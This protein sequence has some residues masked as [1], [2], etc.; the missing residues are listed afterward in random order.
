ML[1][2]MRL[3]THISHDSHIH[4]QNN[5]PPS[6]I[7]FY[8][9][10]IPK[11]ERRKKWKVSHSKRWYLKKKKKIYIHFIHLYCWFGRSLWK[12]VCGGRF[13]FHEKRLFKWCFA[14]CGVWMRFCLIGFTF[15]ENLFIANMKTKSSE[16]C[17]TTETSHFNFI[18]SRFFLMIYGFIQFFYD[19][20]SL[21]LEFSKK[22][23]SK[24]F[25]YISVERPI[26]PLS[27]LQ[28]IFRKFLSTPYTFLL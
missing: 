8:A 4:T 2:T 21:S 28:Q 16:N 20:Y 12:S 17:F 24:V 26:Q 23:V 18:H 14:R 7:S 5:L 13:V 11:H 6:P 9:M 15:I 1:R 25:K 19:F 10:S 22:N 3:T 27:V